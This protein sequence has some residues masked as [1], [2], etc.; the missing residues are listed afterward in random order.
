MCLY[1][2]KFE[3]YMRQQAAAEI[4][5]MTHEE[6]M[7]RV[8]Q[9]KISVKFNLQEIHKPSEKNINLMKFEEFYLPI[10]FIIFYKTIKFVVIIK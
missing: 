3:T 9:M 10:I 2:V 6:Q 4:Q 1:E 8:I 5:E 7:A